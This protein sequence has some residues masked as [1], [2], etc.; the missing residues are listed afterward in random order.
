[1]LS[2]NQV[3]LVF[4]CFIKGHIII[5]DSSKPKGY[6]F[7]YDANVFLKTTGVR[8]GIAKTV[9]SFSKNVVIETVL[10]IFPQ[11][12]LIESMQSDVNL[13]VM[14]KREILVMSAFH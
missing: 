13:T 6:A 7:R 5:T 3:V 8:C 14:R 12:Q 1:M 10:T 11:V 9:D 2:S 4:R